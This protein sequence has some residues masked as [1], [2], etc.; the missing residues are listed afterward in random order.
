MKSS[1]HLT[2]LHQ[3][4]RREGE[5]E[6]GNVWRWGELPYTT[7]S[8]QHLPKEE[9]AVEAK[10][11]VAREGGWWSG[12]RRQQVEEEGQGIL[13]EDLMK[14]PDKL[15]HYLH[16][17]TSPYHPSPSSL[18]PSSSPQPSGPLLPS[19]SMVTRS[20]T[21]THPIAAPEEGLRD[22]LGVEAPLDQG[23][24]PGAPLG[25]GLASLE[26]PLGTGE[27]LESTR[28]DARDP[29]DLGDLKD[30]LDTRDQ[31]D[32]LGPLEEGSL[33]DPLVHLEPFLDPLEGQ[34]PLVHQEE[35]RPLE[36]PATLEA[37]HPLEGQAPLQ[38]GHTLEGPVLLEAGPPLEDGPLEAD[39]PL[40]AGHPME[41]E[42]LE[43]EPLDLREV[44]LAIEGAREEDCESGHGPR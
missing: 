10:E 35:G 7:P 17:P 2:S 23:Q 11:G 41:G 30:P 40:E 44:P 5:D 38:A 25:P 29:L 42:L 21:P 16:P 27:H 4:T 8:P 12:W 19:H 3:V 34:A 26:D 36:G 9:V 1:P 13:L 14:D 6:A 24:A 31:A 37:G 18:P 32:P 28:L 39:H 20:M 33:Q 43:G 22:P 15:S